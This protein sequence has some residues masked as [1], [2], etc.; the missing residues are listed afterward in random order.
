MERRGI[1]EGHLAQ[2]DDQINLVDCDGLGECLGEDR[3]STEVLVATQPHDNPLVL[4]RYAWRGHAAT[5]ELGP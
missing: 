3:H 4:S 1:N 2:V 5:V